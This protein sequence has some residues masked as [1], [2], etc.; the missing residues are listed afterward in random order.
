MAFDIRTK[1]EQ[2]RWEDE[3]NQALLFAE[4]ALWS[5]MTDGNLSEDEVQGIVQVVQCIPA[6]ADYDVDDAV[7]MLEEMRDEY[8]GS[9]ESIAERIVGVAQSLTDPTLR[10]LCYQLMT[11]CAGDDGK[12]SEAEVSFLQMCQEAFEIDD[13]EA[14]SLVSE[15]FPR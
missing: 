15:V 7:E 13:T 5:A 9:A 2:V 12:F 8:G 3:E 6:L 1:F 4:L 14:E 10:R 11:V